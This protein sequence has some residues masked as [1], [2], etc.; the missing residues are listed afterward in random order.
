M[1]HASESSRAL[2][3]IGLRC[4]GKTSVGAELARLRGWEFSDLDAELLALARE[5]AAFDSAGDVL[6]RLGLEV[7]RALE[8]EV[9][10][11]ALARPGPM[12]LATGG[13]VVERE[14]NRELLAGATCVWL[15]AEP[16]VLCARMRAD[17]TTR[18]PLIETRTGADPLLEIEALL[19]RRESWYR[20]L[21]TV[22]IDANAGSPSA[23]CASVEAALS[24]GQRAE[25]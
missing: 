23:L 12:V 6:A 17:S 13:G 8:S 14:S 20:A 3:L 24:K 5:S 15:R 1:A 18:P 4:S 10:V 21:A 11:C 19:E 2:C 9:L 25:P 22:A 7:F 16:E